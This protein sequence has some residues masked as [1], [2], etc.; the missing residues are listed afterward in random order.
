MLAAAVAKSGDVAAVQRVIDVIADASQPEWQRHGA[1]AGSRRRVAGARRGAAVAAATV[2]VAAA[3]CLGSVRRVAASRST[4]GRGVSLPAEPAGLTTLASGHGCDRAPR[5]E[6]VGEA[7]LA[8]TAGARRHGGA[9]HGRAAEAF[10]CRRG[11]LQE[12][13][14]RL[15]P[16]RRAA[17]RTSW[18]RISSTRRL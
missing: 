18:A 11:D 8:G 16:G 5:E 13:L 6:C 17:A 2:E 4:P 7:G 14:R 9:A 10:R 15:S 12:H 3:A 1:A